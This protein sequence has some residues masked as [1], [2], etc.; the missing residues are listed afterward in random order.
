MLLKQ[1]Y[2]LKDILVV[3]KKLTLNHHRLA[4]HRKIKIML[5]KLQIQT[6]NRA[7]P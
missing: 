1:K 5:L 2:Q 3:T 6:T 4:T 7:R